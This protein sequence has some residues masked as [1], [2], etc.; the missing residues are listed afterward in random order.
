M[1]KSILLL[2]V[3][4]LFASYNSIACKCGV[5]PIEESFERSDFVAIIKL[6]NV[7]PDSKNTA[8]HNADVK[9]LTLYKG[10]Q[11]KKIRI[12][13]DLTSSCSFL[14]SEN[15]TWLVYASK[16]EGIIGIGY[17]SADEVADN[18]HFKLKQLSLDFLKTHR[19]LAINPSRLNYYISNLKSLKGYKNKNK[20]A[21]HQVYINSDLTIG[22][23]KSIQKFENARLNTDYITVL[24]KSLNIKHNEPLNK[25]TLITIICYYYEEKGQPSF[26]S[27]YL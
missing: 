14:P 10:E 19:N 5:Q 16:F 17:C 12:Y 3:S 15:S 6:T 1:K 11:L 2:I 20:M 18:S 27:Q 23:I 21:V 25:P 24:K 8:L 7:K 13:S 9:I 22:K 4:L 26:V